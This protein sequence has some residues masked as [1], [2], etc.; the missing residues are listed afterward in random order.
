MPPP[1]PPGFDEPIHDAKIL[2]NCAGFAIARE[3]DEMNT[4][5]FERLMRVNTL[6]TAFVIRALLPGMKAAG[7]GRILITSSM[8][9]QVRLRKIGLDFWA[10]FLRD[11]AATII[12][13]AHLDNKIFA[14]LGVSFVL[15]GGN[16]WVCRVAFLVAEVTTR[17]FSIHAVCVVMVYLAVMAKGVSRLYSALLKGQSTLHFQAGLSIGKPRRDSQVVHRAIMYGA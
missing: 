12:G 1:P 15:I 4:A 6:G 3:F 10:I 9:G 2:A 5:D 11:V 17:R 13:P 8:V 16:P 7:G 14:T